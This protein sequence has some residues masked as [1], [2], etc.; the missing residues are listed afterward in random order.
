MN[1]EQPRRVT[2]GQVVGVHGVRG[3]VKLISHTRPRTNIFNYPQWWLKP[4]IGDWQLHDLL[5]GRSQGKGL[6]AELAGISDRDQARALMDAEIAIER[7]A[8]PELPAGEYYWSD[9]IGL[10]VRR[11][12]GV[13]LGELVELEET[14]ANDVLVVRTTAGA[15]QRIPYVPGLY[16]IQVDLDAGELLVHWPM[17][18]D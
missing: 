3:A 17:E 10:Q 12:D 6:V 9:L 2:L 8:L 4:I 13:V 7:T 5:H 16:V 1:A 15:E 11:T 14:G 18:A